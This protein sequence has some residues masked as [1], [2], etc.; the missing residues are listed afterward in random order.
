MYSI[1]FSILK[2]AIKVK[3]MT[4]VVALEEGL[5]VGAAVTLSELE[6]VCREAIEKYPKFQT[7]AFVEIQKMLHWFAG[8]QIRNV[9]AVGGNI[10]TGSPI[11]DLN[12]IFMATRQAFFQSNS[13]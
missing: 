12:P 1:N 3:E 2:S 11:S 6:A 10:A 4:R 9:S 5:S 13:V 7:E 8:P